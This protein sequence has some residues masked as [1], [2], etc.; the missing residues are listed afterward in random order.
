MRQRRLPRR[1]PTKRPD[2]ERL[3]PLINIVFLLLVFFMVLGRIAPADPFKIEPTRSIAEGAAPE[4]PVLIH[5]GRDG[6]LALEGEILPEAA[7]IER[8]ALARDTDTAKDIRV[9]ADAR[10]EAVRV[11]ALLRA[12]RAAGVERVRLLTVRGER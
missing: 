4:T 5:I 1:R 7:L 11:A 3:L 10:A 6:Q 2:D 8:L 12:L 9:K